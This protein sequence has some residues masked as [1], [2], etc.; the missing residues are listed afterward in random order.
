MVYLK[1]KRVFDLFVALLA[2]IFL[3]PIM[4]IVSTAILVKMGRPVLFKQDRPGLYGKLFRMYKFRTMLPLDAHR[5][6]SDKERISPLG[7]FLRSTSLDELPELFNVVKGD[8]S[9]IG[10]R[11]LLVEYLDKYSAYQMQR[12]DVLP[13][14]TGLAQVQGRNKL[15]WKNKFR[16]DVFYTRKIS[17]KLDIFIFF[18]TIKVVIFKEN[19]KLSGEDSKFK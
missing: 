18:K 10:P 2:L 11:P 5:D 3:W 8:M 9:I 16:Y 12:H 7:R 19:F 6:L 14:I 4:L 17:W 15:S 1:E 13:G